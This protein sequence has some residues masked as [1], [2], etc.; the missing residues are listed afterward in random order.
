MAAMAVL[1]ETEFLK[2]VAQ[3][4][5]R[6]M[7]F[8]GAGAS[9]ASGMPTAHDITWD[10][11]RKYYCLQENQ[12]LQSHD[13]NNKAM[14]AKIQS[15]L[16]SKG[17]PPVNSTE[18]Y[19]FYFKA[20]F[21]SDLASQQKYIREK[22]RSD[23][24][25]LTIGNRVLA[26][27]LEMGQARLVFTTNFDEV[28]ETAYS[29][30]TGRNLSAFHLEGSYAAL[31]ALNDEQF[32]I[33]AKIHG[34]FRYQSIKNLS[35]DLLKNDEHIRKAFLAAATRYGL[36]VSGYSG[37]DANVMQLLDEALQQ[38]NAFP[39]GV[40]WTVPKLGYI[41]S[42]VV[43]FVDKARKK[44][45]GAFIVETGTFDEMLSKIWKQTDK[46]PSNL[47]AK[48]RSAAFESVAIPLP[49]S[50]KLYPMLRTNALLILAPPRD[51]G[52]IEYDGDISYPALKTR[53]IEHDP[54]AVIALTDK[55][56]FWG[57][58]EEIEKVVDK[59]KIKSF[60]K[61][62]FD[63]PVQEI[64]NSTFL[65]AFFEEA[66]ARALCWGKPLRLRK[67]FKTYYAIVSHEER[68][69]PLLQP[70]RKAIGYKGSL[71]TA[72]GPVPGMKDV[73]WA[74]A[75]SLRLEERNG[76][77]W[78]L[79]KPDIWISPLAQRQEATEFVRNKVLKR[80]NRQSS[81]IL[82][83]WI[84]ILLG[85]TGRGE[86]EVSCFPDSQHPAAF[87]IVTR[88]AYSRYGGGDAK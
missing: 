57:A 62:E 11:K 44:G 86:V 60:K 63:N 67:R 29:S 19:S 28:V 52:T 49:T 4:Q 36:I 53:I 47:D 51:C 66:L 13:V 54:A 31:E 88:S 39:H 61:L 40:F 33:Y 35:D 5:L 26:A 55:L 78:L 6:L 42:V 20:T 65:K 23:L 69:D 68:D 18:E 84:S 1:S 27:L 59:V 16:D 48:V 21:G 79:I 56:V 34:D 74:E 32:P 45:I 10:L 14:R 85:N 64:V 2:H 58:Q 30:V 43:D 71:G 8:L 46:R 17:F 24:I 9:R 38:N 82:S 15:Y 3:N 70:L 83:A 75:A 12:T 80:W 41:S 77:L 72:N 50:G 73:F 25:S 22:L 76:A 37:R 81:D 7:W 87:E